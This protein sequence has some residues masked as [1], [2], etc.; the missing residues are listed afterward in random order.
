M[1]V[2]SIDLEKKE[3]VV[4]DGTIY[5]ILFDIPNDITIEEFQSLLDE[6]C[7]IVKRI[8]RNE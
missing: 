5:P 1:K 7:D 2:I 8:T 6:S 4:E 3:F